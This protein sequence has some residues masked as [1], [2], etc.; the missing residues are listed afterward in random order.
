MK[1][2][3]LREL[4]DEAY[5]SGVI[6]G[7][8]GLVV[9]VRNPDASIDSD[10]AWTESLVVDVHIDPEGCDLDLLTDSSEAESRMTLT[11]LSV[12]LS[13]LPADFDE[14]AVF[15]RGGHS[16]GAPGS[17]IDGPVVASAIDTDEQVLAVIVEFEGYEDQ[18]G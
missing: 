6:D 9:L 5:G 10:S 18:L 15:V 2:A 17:F 12:R 7:T 13:E 3:A 4:I 11:E 14:F 8:A 16:N 1:L